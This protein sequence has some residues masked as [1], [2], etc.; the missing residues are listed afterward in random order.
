MR[1][2]IPKLKRR[3]EDLNSFDP[4]AMNEEFD[5]RAAAIQRK[6]DDTLV[7]IL[8]PDTLDYR[9]FKISYL[10]DG[11]V[12][13]G[14][15]KLDTVR[16]G[17]RSG[18]ADAISK[19]QTLIERFEEKLG[20]L[21]ESPSGRALRNFSGLDLH[22]EIKRAVEGLFSNGYY[23]NAVEDAC[24][25]LDALVRMRSGRDDLSGTDLMLKVFSPN[26]PILKF[27]NLAN[28]SDRSEQQ[29]MMYLHAGA[30]LAFRNPR[31]HALISD[32][33]EEALEIISFIS[34]LAKVLDSAA[35]TGG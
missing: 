20:D 33:A 2:A 12:V 21:G 4:D 28:D 27:N 29:G 3:I 17:F 32:E 10:Y 24:K 23:A 8:G 5:P 11:P 15:V 26:G 1:T 14:G 6:I 34:F 18:K 7:E 13:R 30:M 9:R 25:V 35:K 22:P 16:E 19:L 31:A